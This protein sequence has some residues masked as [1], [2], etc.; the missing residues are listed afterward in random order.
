MNQNL[1]SYLLA[2]IIIGALAR[3][4]SEYMFA[5]VNN[6]LDP[7]NNFSGLQAIEKN[8]QSFVY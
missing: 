6:T 4:M 7:V 8:L 1:I 2:A 5:D 3:W